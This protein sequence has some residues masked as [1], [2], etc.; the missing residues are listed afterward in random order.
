MLLPAP[1]TIAVILSIVTY[2]I[3]VSWDVEL[4]NVKAKTIETSTGYWVI[5]DNE[6]NIEWDGFT[7]D[8]L[9][10]PKDTLIDVISGNA[11]SNGN[12]YVATINVNLTSKNGK[13]S[14]V[15]I[16]VIQDS[17]A[18][19]LSEMWYDGLWG[20]KGLA[21]AIQMMLMLLLGHVLALSKP[22]DNLLNKIVPACNSTAKAALIVTA[23]TVCF[24]LINWGL[25]LIIGA[26]FARKIGEFSL[27]SGIGI[28]YPLIGAAGYSGLMVWHGGISGSSLVKVSEEGHFEELVTNKEVLS[29]LPE[30]I[31]FTETVFSTMNISVSLALI[32]LLPAAM[33]LIGKRLKPSE[34]NLSERDVS[35]SN[36]TEI[37]GA[38]RLD[39]S[40]VLAYLIG[41]FFIVY[42]IYKAYLHPGAS[43]LKFMNPNFINF[44]LIGL[45]MCFHG[46]F[47]KML[48][49]VD[50]AIKG[51]SGILLQF[52]LYFGIM[53]LLIGSGL[54]G[55]ISEAFKAISSETS[56]PVLTFFSS[57][58]VNIF[59]PSGG[60]QWYVQGPIVLQTALEM[61]IP[62]AKSVMALAYGDQITNMLQPFWALPLLGITGLKAR[63]ILPYTL[64][65]MAIGIVIFVTALL[66]F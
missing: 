51:V 1:F 50:Q 23:V 43:Q 33:Y 19:Q 29:Q 17:K 52:P 37:I 26:V 53:G 63:Q 64:F 35:F 2:V 42:A 66:L 40:R 65:L 15:S 22:I 54:I 11:S 7:N 25:G 38:E 32:I 39:H 31:P 10:I 44:I 45:V 16:D 62:L 61:K 12:G 28:N 46:C 47:S 21:F 8:S 9:Y 48:S 24:S 14:D 59:V 49:A 13:V 34:I 18:F 5:S 3:A 6:Q 58:L 56:Y 30:T 60:G 20:I 57:G 36:N 55:E 41:G 27:K 4:P